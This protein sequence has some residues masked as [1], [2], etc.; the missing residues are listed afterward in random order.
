MNGRTAFKFW[1]VLFASGAPL[2]ADLKMLIQSEE[3]R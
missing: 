2:L 3:T 1:T